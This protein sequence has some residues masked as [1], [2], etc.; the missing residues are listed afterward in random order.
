MGVE[1]GWNASGIPDWL[2]EAAKCMGL[3][4]MTPVQKAAIPLLLGNKDVVVNLLSL[5]AITCSFF[6]GRGTNRIRQDSRV[7]D[8][9]PYEALTF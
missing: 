2:V 4:H 3:S 8:P 1:H 5:L 9:T 6:L 7:P